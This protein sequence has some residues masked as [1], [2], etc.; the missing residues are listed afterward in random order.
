MFKEIFFF[1]KLSVLCLC[2]SA[3]ASVCAC[4]SEWSGMKITEDAAH[5]MC[6][7]ICISSPSSFFFKK[8]CSI[9][10]HDY[11]LHTHLHCNTSIV[12]LEH[13]SVHLYLFADERYKETYI[14]DF[15]FSVSKGARHPALKLKHTMNIILDDKYSKKW[16]VPSYSSIFIKFKQYILAVVHCIMYYIIQLSLCIMYNMSL[17][18]F[19]FMQLLVIKSHH[20]PE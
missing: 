15:T 7:F 8:S 9:L 3:P 6:L 11:T 20:R 12:P 14:L 19:Q 1:H 4:G 5:S 13:Q 17:Q 10:W 16:F 2:Y 18:Y